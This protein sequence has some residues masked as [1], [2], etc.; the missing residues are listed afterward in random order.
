MQHYPLLIGLGLLL[1]APVMAVAQPSHVDAAATG[2]G[3]GTSWADAFTDL[4]AALLSAESGDEVWVAEGVYTPHPTSRFV[5]FELSDGVALYGGFPAGGS[6]FE[7]RDPDAYE[8]VLS[9]DLAGDDDTG[10]DT[11]ENARHVVFIDGTATPVTGSTVLDGFTITAGNADGEFPSLGRAGGGLMCYGEGEGSECSPTLS[12]VTFVRNRARIPGGGAAFIGSFGGESSPT[13]TDVAFSRNTAVGGGALFF[14][15]TGGGLTAPEI[16]D[17][18]FTGNTASGGGGAIDFANIGGALRASLTRVAF[19]ENGCVPQDGSGELCGSGGAV[20]VSGRSG[21]GQIAFDDVL[22]SGNTAFEGGVIDTEVEE[23]GALTVTFTGV[24]FVDNACEAQG[25]AVLLN[26]RAGTTSAA[27]ANVKFIGNSA[28]FA[29]GGVRLDGSFSGSATATFA[30]AI[31][32]GN[33]AQTRGGATE[34]LASSGA[35]SATFSNTTFYG[36]TAGSGSVL[37]AFGGNGGDVEVAFDNAILWANESGGGPTSLFASSVSFDHALVEGGCPD[38]TSCE[39]LLTDAPLFADPAGPDGT[40]GTPDDDLRLLP[41]SPA[42]DAGSAALLPP[43]TADLDGDGDTAEPLPLDLAGGPRVL[44]PTPDLG[45]YEGSATVAAAPGVPTPGAFALSSL[46]PNPARGHV[47]AVLTVASAQDVRAEVF[48]VLGRR[49][50][51]VFEGAVAAGAPQAV[52]FD[53]GALP[54]GLYVLRVRAAGA[55]LTR[56]F[57]VVR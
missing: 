28:G 12:N 25:G 7:D 14:A 3:D 43:D 18:E 45:P 23:G 56:P 15:S 49:V 31:F 39:A 8:T 27:F 10:G 17:A 55:S 34:V 19:V 46:W 21:D 9:G 1:S 13:L 24:V 2:T 44:G 32:V 20:F 26:G 37:D 16:S 41:G 42:L 52:R 36:N 30:N 33:S 40:V 57:T 29:G 47:E 5:S 11:G 50:A 54:A 6:T 48:D 38:F 35:A 51:V 4:R 22:F 53:A